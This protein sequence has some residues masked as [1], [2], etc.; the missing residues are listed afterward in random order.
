MKARFPRLI[1]VSSVLLVGGLF[2]AESAPQTAAPVARITAEYV[3]AEKFTDF[4][5][6]IMESEKARAGLITQFNEHLASLGK[7]LPDGQRLELRFTNIDLAGDYEPWRG[8]DFDDIR[9]MKDIYI[10][11]MTVEYKL[12]DASGAVIRSG[13]ERISDM[14]YLMS[15]RLIPDNDPLR[16]DKNMLTDWVRREFRKPAK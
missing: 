16:Y 1:F 13:S 6:S 3:G 14:S 8:P 2:G 11:R 12:L 10:P 7:F 5:D 4:R 15:A 9:I